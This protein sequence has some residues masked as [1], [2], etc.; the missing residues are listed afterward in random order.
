MTREP[1][2]A[3][4]IVEYYATKYSSYQSK[5]GNGPFTHVHT[6]LYDRRQFSFLAGE[7]L[8]LRTFGVD[9]LRFM[10]LMGQ[11]ALLE[12]LLAPVRERLE[13]IGNEMLV[14]DCGAGHGG[15]A[16]TLALSYGCRVH[17][18][19]LAPQQGEHIARMAEHL[20]ITDRIKVEVRDLHESTV[21]TGTYDLIV[22]IDALCQIGRWT[23]S[24]ELLRHRL[25]IGG[26]LLISDDYIRRPGDPFEGRFNAHWK[27]A[28]TSMDEV[29]KWIAS[30]GTALRRYEDLSRAQI[31]FWLL[32][33]A[34]TRLLQGG[35]DKDEVER[36]RLESSRIFHE[37]M[38]DAFS[39]GAMRYLQLEVAREA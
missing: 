22:A 24:V 8:D 27:S 21:C 33:I 15:T 26:R 7:D 31:P 20:G 13:S 35:G 30:H 16:F 28:I 36:D 18:L 14:L 1:P 39:G 29:G 4:E 25:R 9:A 12:H 34:H 10:L 6:G 23:S 19:V 38:R 5:Y 2:P 17:A 11:A 32:S 3:R 37:G